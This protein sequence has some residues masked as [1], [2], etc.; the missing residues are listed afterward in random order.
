MPRAGWLKWSIK[1]PLS[2]LARITECCASGS[3]GLWMAA[4]LAATE[5]V[6]HHS[7]AVDLD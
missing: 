5:S 7:L 4:T 6:E 3:C 2:G 1:K